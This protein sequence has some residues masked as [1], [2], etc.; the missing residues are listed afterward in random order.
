MLT[1]RN[2]F[3]EEGPLREEARIRGSRKRK[4]MET[5]SLRMLL[6]FYRSSYLELDQTL[7]LVQRRDSLQRPFVL[8]GV[9]LLVWLVSFSSGAVF[10]SSRVLL[11]HIAFST[12]D[13]CALCAT[14]AS[15]KTC[16]STCQLPSSSLLPEQEWP[17]APCC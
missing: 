11:S 12:V 13:F 8:Q 16:R 5:F 15:T 10:L 6:S 3:R 14:L 7:Q 1:N 17:S 2:N 4:E 9:R